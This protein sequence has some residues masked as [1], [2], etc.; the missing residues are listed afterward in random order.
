MRRGQGLLRGLVVLGTAEEHNLFFCVEGRKRGERGKTVFYFEFLNAATA[1][2]T[3]KDDDEEKN[4]KERTT[5]THVRLRPVDGVVDPAAGLLHADAP[6]FG[7]FRYFVRARGERERREERE[8]VR[9]KR[10]RSRSRG[11]N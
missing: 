2:K 4:S 6:P 11:F 9:E 3:K 5:N 8:S 10:S 7:L 1:E